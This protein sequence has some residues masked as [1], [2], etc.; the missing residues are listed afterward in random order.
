MDLGSQLIGRGHQGFC[1]GL[2]AEKLACANIEFGRQR[3][4]C[5][6]VGI[7]SIEDDDGNVFFMSPE[8]AFTNGI[9][10]GTGY[11]YPVDLIGYR[12]IEKV[13]HVRD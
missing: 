12:I 13:G 2:A 8:D 4:G 3:P 10:I 1:V 9:W 6:R 7:C 11:A 5:S